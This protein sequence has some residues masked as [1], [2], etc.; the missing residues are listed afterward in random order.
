MRRGR[1]QRA[2]IGAWIL[3]LRRWRFPVSAA[4]I[5]ALV[6]QALLGGVAV[7]APIAAGKSAL[8]ICTDEGT[9]GDGT[10]L[11][12]AAGAAHQQHGDTC[13]CQ[14]LCA[15][16]G[17]AAPGA[18]FRAV[19][20]RPAGEA[21]RLALPMAITA[22]ELHDLRHFGFARAPPSFGRDIT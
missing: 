20:L 9:S 2:S 15:H 19:G 1:S 13:V 5:Y 7:A 22:S 12:D 18:S 4:A 21:I 10:R 6:L 8:V 17:G 3:R 14:G 11:A 16:H